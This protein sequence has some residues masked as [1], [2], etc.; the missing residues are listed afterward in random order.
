MN[1]PN[2]FLFLAWLCLLP[3]GANGAGPVI[4]RPSDDPQIARLLAAEA[5]SKSLAPATNGALSNL[6]WI[7]KSLPI[8]G[9]TWHPADVAGDPNAAGSWFGFS[10]ASSADYVVVGAP[11]MNDFTGK[12]YLFRRIGPDLSLEATLSANDA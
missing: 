8:A 4:L 2:S 7:G 11:R 9:T 12:A 5:A 6:D 10:V 3:L 1:R